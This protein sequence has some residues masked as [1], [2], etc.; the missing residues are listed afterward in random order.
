M[1][2]FVQQ[3]YMSDGEWHVAGEVFP[4]YK[5]VATIKAARAKYEMSLKEAKEYVEYLRSNPNTPIDGQVWV[6]T[7]RGEKLKPE[8]SLPDIPVSIEGTLR[9]GTLRYSV[10]ISADS[11]PQAGQELTQL[12]KGIISMLPESVKE[13]LPF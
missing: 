2:K 10:N 5:R 4:D 12:A 1:D 7:V 9:I 3:T 8:D 13:N 6:R 11:L